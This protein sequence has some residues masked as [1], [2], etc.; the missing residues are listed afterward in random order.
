MIYICLNYLYYINC[1]EVMVGRPYLLVH[2][3]KKGDG[4]CEKKVGGKNRRH[5]PHART[6]ASLRPIGIL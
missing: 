4:R 1:I 2:S 6:T 5:Y 3:R